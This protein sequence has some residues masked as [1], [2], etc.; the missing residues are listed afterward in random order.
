MAKYYNINDHPVSF[1]PGDNALWKKEVSKAAGTKKMA[2]IWESPYTFRE[3]N[4]NG[5]Y[6]LTDRFG[7]DGPFPGMHPT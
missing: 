7:D 2:P 6:L 1:K 3:A 5:S 4:P